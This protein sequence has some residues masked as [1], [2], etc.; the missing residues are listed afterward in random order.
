MNLF[1]NINKNRLSSLFPHLKYDNK[2][3]KS[4]EIKINI[5]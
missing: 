5:F 4:K 2:L 1:F 3:T